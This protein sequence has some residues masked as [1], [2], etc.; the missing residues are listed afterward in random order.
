MRYV[1]QVYYVNTVCFLAPSPQCPIVVVPTMY[2]GVRALLSR[3]TA[4]PSD[5]FLLVRTVSIPTSRIFLS[6][7]DFMVTSSLSLAPFNTATIVRAWACC[8]RHSDRCVRLGGRPCQLRRWERVVFLWVWHI[9]MCRFLHPTNILK[10][11][12]NV[13]PINDFKI[14]RKIKA[15]TFFFNKKMS[16]YNYVN[17]K[18]LFFFSKLLSQVEPKLTHDVYV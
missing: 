11:N 5:H 16:F 14:N 18:K 7:E 13:I 17:L 2:L 4:M 6:L 3:L 1:L 12:S 15:Y 10:T 8:C 9:S